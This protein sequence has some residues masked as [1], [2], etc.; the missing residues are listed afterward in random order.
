MYES[1]SHKSWRIVPHGTTTSPVSPTG[2]SPLAQNHGGLLS[3]MLNVYL[4]GKKG[5]KAY[6]L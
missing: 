6:G 1:F 4:R 3:T 5:K 2:S